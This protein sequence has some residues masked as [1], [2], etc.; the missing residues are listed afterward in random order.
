[1]QPL[2]ELTIVVPTRNESANIEAFLDSIPA[3]AALIVVDKS[4]DGTADIVRRRRPAHTI[5]LECAGSL[6]QAREIGARA[7][8]T[9]WLLFTDA[10]IRFAPG[11]FAELSGALRIAGRSVAMLLGPK[12]SADEYQGHYRRLAVAQKVLARLGC[13]PRAVRTCWSRQKRSPPSAASTPGSRVTRTRSSAGVSRGLASR[14]AV[15]L[16]LITFATD[17]R[18]LRRGVLRKTLHTVLRC[19]ALYLGVVPRRGARTIGVTGARCATSPTSSRKAERRNSAHVPNGAASLVNLGH[20]HLGGYRLT[21][22]VLVALALRQNDGR[23]RFSRYRNCESR[24]CMQLRRARFLSTACT[25]HHGASVMCV[26]ESMISFAR[27]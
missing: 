1:M 25:T 23:L 15:T 27:V 12:L 18:R 6:T 22:V 13:R 19:S 21:G 5:V 9:R 26:R 17:H 14:G 16:T 8:R 4:T 3:E 20:E 7:A 2:E 24:W 11:Y 10:D